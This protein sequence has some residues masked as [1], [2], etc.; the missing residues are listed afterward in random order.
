MSIFAVAMVVFLVAPLLLERHR[1]PGIVGIV[2]V[3]AAIGPNAAGILDR[4]PA[5]V[6]LGDVGLIYLMFLA[7]VEI[8][9]HRFFDNIDQ[10]VVFGV[11]TFLVPQAIGT[12]FGGWV[13]GFSASTAL[14]F[15][16]I[17]AS[18]T[19]VAYPV[20]H[21]LG[22]VGNDAVTATVGGTVLTNVLALLVLVVVVASTEAALDWLFWAR[23]GAGLVLLFVG[24][25]Y[26][27]PWFGRRFFR[28]LAEESYFEY[29]FVMAALFVSAGFAAVVGAEPIIGALVAGLALNRLIPDR[30][31][32]MNRIQFVGDALFVP[33][34][35]LS[36]GLLVDPAALVGSRESLV[37]AGSLVGLTVATKFA[38]AWTT[39]RLYAYGREQVLSVFGLS[40]GQAEAL[41]IVLIA[42]EAGVPGFDVDMINGA[43]A[44]ILVVSLVSPIVVEK[45][46]RALAIAERRQRPSTGARQRILVP[47]TPIPEH[48]ETLLQYH[49]SLLDLAFLLREEDSDE[50]LHTLTVVPPGPETEREIAAARSA[51]AHTEEYAAG[52]EVP[53]SFHTRVDHNVASGIVRAAIETQATT[54]LLDRDG[55][56]LPR[57][58][59]FSHATRQVLRWSDRLVLVS[60]IREPLNTVSRIAVVLP[61]QV[62]HDPGV[63]EVVRTVDRIAAG[64]G[65][66]VRG[67]AVGDAAERY[68]QMFSALESVAD[69][70]VERVDDWDRLFA[71]L[72]ERASVDDLVVCASARPNT[73]G[74]Q[75]EL[76]TLDDR[77]PTIVEGDFVVVYPASGDLVEGR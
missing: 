77:L 9:L 13:L 14:L 53:V 16:A 29:L 35:L 54:I 2:L 5:I 46:G 50:P 69:V 63:H 17:F 62:A 11:L 49:E 70:S 30:G 34:F 58:P 37:L 47:F 72:A 28:S 75:P 64:T 55:I 45:Y 31:P 71:V 22:I 6:L 10:S 12:A 1:L 61:P 15:A 66:P 20:A 68:R 52:A 4:S 65:A 38:A 32:L 43:V 24:V 7:G 40:I 23:L 19:L 41:S 26:V 59:L 74:W 44:M 76:R 42:F 57:Q 3:G 39:G 27:V 73:V 21:R 60:R 48:H 67:I 33:F 18:H 25:W 8:D 36:I 51:I 56:R